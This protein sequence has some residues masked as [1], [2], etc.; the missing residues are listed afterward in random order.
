MTFFLKIKCTV[1]YSH[2]LTCLNLQA[3]IDIYQFIYVYIQY[4]Q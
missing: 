2:M 1:R 4:I 3:H